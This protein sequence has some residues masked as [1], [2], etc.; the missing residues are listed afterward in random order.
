MGK[1]PRLLPSTKPHEVFELI[2]NLLCA[3]IALNIS[4]GLFCGLFLLW[5]AYGAGSDFR[6]SLM[7]LV[8]N[9]GFRVECVLLSLVS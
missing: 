3:L 5:F 1:P 4:F 2:L 9:F 8:V 7:V 6:V